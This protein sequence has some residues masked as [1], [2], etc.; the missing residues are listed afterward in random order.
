MQR[1]LDRRSLLRQFSFMTLVALLFGAVTHVTSAQG[2]PPA[3]PPPFRSTVQVNSSSTF[4]DTAYWGGPNVVNL[5]VK[6]LGCTVGCPMCGGYRNITVAVETGTKTPAEIATAIA[7]AINNDIN[8]AS[9]GVK[10]KAINDS[11]S[12]SSPNGPPTTGTPDQ[13]IHTGELNS[14]GSPNENRISATYYAR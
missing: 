6:V 9:Q 14:D 4:N 10:A 2:G 7:Q 1:I 12:I 8:A 5:T 3:P 11:V 13:P